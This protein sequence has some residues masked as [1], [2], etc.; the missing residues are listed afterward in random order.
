M[1]DYAPHSRT[2]DK[3]I[4]VALAVVALMNGWG[5]LVVT[6]IHQDVSELRGQLFAALLNDKT[7]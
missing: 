5:L 2:N 6:R 1:A 7:R 3:L 4:T